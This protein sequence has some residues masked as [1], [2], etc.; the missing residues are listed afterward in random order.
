MADKFATNYNPRRWLW[1]I[2]HMSRQRIT[3]KLRKNHCFIEAARLL[4]ENGLR[5]EVHPPTGK[6]HPFLLIENPDPSQEPIKMH[7]ACTPR[8]RSPGRF[9][10]TTLRRKLEAAGLM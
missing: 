1:G 9:T 8:S 3:T 10:I 5:Y 2:N 4:D 6:G 7:I